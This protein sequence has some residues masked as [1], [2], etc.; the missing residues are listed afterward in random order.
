VKRILVATRSHHKLGE[1]RQ[2]LHLPGIELVDLDDVGIAGEPVEDGETFTENALL[3]ARWGAERSGLPTLADDSGIEVDGLGGGPGVRTKRYAGEAAT[4][5]DNNAKLLA[6][7]ASLGALAPEARGARYVC[8][9]AMVDPGRPEAPLI[10]EGDFVGRI[11]ATPRGTG[12]FGYDP[13]F[14]PDFEPPGGRTV[15]Q[16]RQAEK[17]A[18]SHRAKA[19][20][21]MA[22]A[23]RRLGY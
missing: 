11:A 14:E 2:L 16:M 7:L 4:D 1:L 8:I 17:N 6:E 21:A 15:G 3:K 20:A 10:A 22:D 12:G 23:L 19:A 18:V 13:I 5:A 9:L